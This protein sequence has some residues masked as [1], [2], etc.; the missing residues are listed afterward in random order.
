M[1]EMTAIVLSRLSVRT[2]EGSNRD[3]EGGGGEREM[4]REERGGEQSG[5]RPG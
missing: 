4:E 5:D 3:F 1:T 2:S